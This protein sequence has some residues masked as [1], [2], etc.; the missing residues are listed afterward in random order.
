MRTRVLVPLAA[1]TL[2]FGWVHV[3]AAQAPSGTKSFDPT[4]TNT[5]AAIKAATEA[6]RPAAA[7]AKG[8]Q[9][10]RETPEAE[11]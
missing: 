11:R 5:D 8:G 9:P 7:A 3:C 2:L 4:I 6:A 10:V 1:V